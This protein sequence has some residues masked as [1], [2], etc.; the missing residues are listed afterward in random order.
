MKSLVLLLIIFTAEKLHASLQ[1]SNSKFL[2]SNLFQASTPDSPTY[3]A[4]VVEFSH[5]RNE[6]FTPEQRLAINLARY[7][8]IM[9]EA[10]ANL[11]IILFPE[12]TLNINLTAV[13]IP[14]VAEKI[15]PC[16]NSSYPADG[17]LNQ[18][19]CSARNFKRYVVVN[20]VTKVTCPDADMT[21][22]E[23]P[24]DCSEHKDKMSY[25]NTNVVFDR[26]GTL[27]SRYRKFNLWVGEEKKVDKPFK[28]TM[29]TFDMDFGV[30][31]GS[32]VCFD[33]IFKSP[34]LDLIRQQNITD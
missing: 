34:A 5:E 11:D 27:I 20:M 33:I 8:K 19:S 12:A 13:E 1:I 3:I 16:G 17:L 14:E 15:S 26:N 9:N 10:P 30:K 28:P 4:G 24:R 22:F 7:L 25:Y 23:D 18:I 21:A 2:S 29:V 6:S 31:F 32:F